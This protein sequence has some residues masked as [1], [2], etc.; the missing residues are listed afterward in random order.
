MAHWAFLFSIKI[1]LRKCF[2]ASNR[3]NFV[4][5][6]SIQ[7]TAMR[8][9]SFERASKNLADTCFFKIF[10]CSFEWNVSHLGISKI[11]K[12]S[13]TCLKQRNI[14]FNVVLMGNREKYSQKKKKNGLVVY[15]QENDL[16]DENKF[17]LFLLKR[18]I[19][20]K[21][22]KCVINPWLLDDSYW[23]LQN[24]AKTIYFALGLHNIPTILALEWFH[25]RPNF[26][27]NCIPFH[28]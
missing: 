23:H 5:F 11:V 25:P 21:R 28:G 24:H 3:Y 12:V 4:N 9:V 13:Y 8:H 7:D 17:H 15:T 18:K 16:I 1:T 6:L 26:M 27:V 20:Y 19:I 14:F 2:I 22:N 10:R